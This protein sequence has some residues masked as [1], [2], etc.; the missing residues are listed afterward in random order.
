[1]NE[2]R[3]I[4]I[5]GSFTQ[6]AQEHRI[7]LGNRKRVVF[8]I[9]AVQTNRVRWVTRSFVSPG[10]RSIWMPGSDR[11][12]DRLRSG[13]VFLR[14]AAHLNISL[15]RKAHWKHLA[16]ALLR[17]CFLRVRETHIWRDLDSPFSVGC[18]PLCSCVLSTSTKP[19]GQCYVRDRPVKGCMGIL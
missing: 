13:R 6:A 2:K 14:L 7:D 16:G 8:T 9:H 10:Y 17:F 5:Y 3:L 4:S 1:M 11:G 15:L 12:S 19:F 18:L